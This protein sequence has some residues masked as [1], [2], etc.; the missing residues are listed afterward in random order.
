M[1][2]WRFWW[3]EP[4]CVKVRKPKSNCLW[5]DRKF[6]RSYNQPWAGAREWGRVGSGGGNFHAW[7]DLRAQFLWSAQWSLLL[8]CVQSQTLHESSWQLWT[9]V[10]AHK[11]HMLSSP[12][13]PQKVHCISWF[14]MDQ[15]SISE[16]VTVV[17]RVWYCLAGPSSHGSPCI[18]CCC[19]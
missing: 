7:L 19:L 3:W 10:P 4:V 15:M 9:P 1:Y 8:H 12:E 11:E 13:A 14:W 17:G 2:G 18:S 6:T 16:A 5:Q